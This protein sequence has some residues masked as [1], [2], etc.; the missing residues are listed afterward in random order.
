MVEVG[1]RALSLYMLAGPSEY[2]RNVGKHILHLMLDAQEQLVQQAIT[3]L[4]Q[5]N[6]N[7]DDF[8]QQYEEAQAKKRKKKLRIARLEK[9]DEELAFE[10][11]KGVLQVGVGVGLV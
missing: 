3:F 2:S 10:A 11:D 5:Q 4:Q 8:V 6:D 9:S 1:S 7:L